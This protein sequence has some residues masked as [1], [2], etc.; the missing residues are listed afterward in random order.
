MKNL[1][2]KVLGD[3]HTFLIEIH[4]SQPF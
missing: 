2:T 4:Y 1:K 3:V